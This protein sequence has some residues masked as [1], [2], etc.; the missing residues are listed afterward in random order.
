MTGRK[1]SWLKV[2]HGG[3]EAFGA[4]K[5]TLGGL[6]L[7]TVCEEARCPNRGECWSSGTATFLVLG[8]QCTRGCRFCA[9]RKGHPGGLVDPDEPRRVA[10]A[11]Q[12]WGLR[13]VVVTCVTRDDLPD[14]GAAHLAAVVRA[15]RAEAPAATVE[16]LASDLGGDPAAV[17]TVVGSGPDVFAHNVET[18]DRLQRLVRDPRCSFAR[19][20][21]VLQLAGELRPG[22]VVK[23]ALLLGLGETPEEVRAALRALRDAGVA[24]LTLGQYLAPSPDHAP[25]AAWVPPE[26]FAAWREEAL[27]LGFTAVASGPLV[28]SS[29]RAGALLAECRPTPGG[30]P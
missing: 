24:S 5:G 6:G 13:H 12:A 30:V 19:S 9:V 18:V 10:A 27:A 15:L 22:L 8:D 25:V 28:R 16:V 26:A 7:H 1:P 21:A 29:Y 2:R 3:G 20:L 17:R 14:G 11:A 23:S 4:V